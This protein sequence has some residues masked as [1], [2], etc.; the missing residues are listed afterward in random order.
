MKKYYLLLVFIIVGIGLS[1]GQSKSYFIKGGVNISKP[2]YSVIENGVSSDRDF[3][4]RV[5]FHVGGGINFPILTK[6]EFNFSLQIEVLYSREGY[7]LSFPNS[8]TKLILNLNEI[9]TPILLKKGL[10]DNQ[11]YPVVG[12]YL[13]YVLDARE[14]SGAGNF[15]SIKNDYN[16]FDVG[17]IIG[18]EYR[19]DLGIFVELR[20][21]YGFTNLSLVEY[22]DSSIKHSYKSRVFKVGLGYQF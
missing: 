21:N 9:K 19:F 7:N 4:K 14:N 16:D 18:C 10:F 3:G 11:L 5:S 6:N 13:G 2:K 1:T 22:P 12:G 15:R 20:F 8:D 17:A